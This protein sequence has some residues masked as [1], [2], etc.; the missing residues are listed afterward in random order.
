MRI[1][2]LAFLFASTVYSQE[3]ISILEKKSE[4]GIAFYAVNNTN[5][6]KEV[7]L[8]CKIINL[9]GNKAPVT[10]KVSAKD[11]VLFKNYYFIKG[12]GYSYNYAFSYIE[13]PTEQEIKTLLAKTDQELPKDFNKGIVVFSKDGCPRCH[14]VTNY[15]VTN[16]IKFTFLNVT[17]SDLNNKLMWQLLKSNDPNISSKKIDM[18][19]VLVAG[20]LSYSIENLKNFVAALPKL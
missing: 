3:D 6:T 14:Y 9:K 17:K 2:L 12:K 11:T 19:V 4:K 18:P 20:K 10:K 15:L 1:Y 5:T 16:N 13:T 7:T 8:T